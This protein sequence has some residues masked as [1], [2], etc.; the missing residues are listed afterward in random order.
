MQQVYRIIITPYHF[1]MWDIFIE[2]KELFESLKP[3]NT[4][5]D[6]IN[7]LGVAT[8]ER[9]LDNYLIVEAPYVLLGEKHIKQ[10]GY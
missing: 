1:D 4:V 9:L 7:I 3:A 10:P 6:A 2:D 8:W 5:E